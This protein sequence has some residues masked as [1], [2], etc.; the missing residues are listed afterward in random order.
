M[1]TL[2]AKN[3][4]VVVVACSREMSIQP[5]SL[6]VIVA[7]EKGIGKSVEKQN[8]W[9][10]CKEV[11][12]AKNPFLEKFMLVNWNKILKVHGKLMLR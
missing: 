2:K 4:D 7:K 9:L 8:L 6:F 1:S 12:I 5:N 3:E 11:K 10:K